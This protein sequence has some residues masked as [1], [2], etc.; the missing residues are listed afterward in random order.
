MSVAYA[1]VLSQRRREAG[2]PHGSTDEGGLLQ[3]VQHR[4]PG[5]RCARVHPDVRLCVSLIPDPSQLTEIAT[6]FSAKSS[7]GSARPLVGLRA[8]RNC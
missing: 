6:A 8:P 1:T 7:P 5:R 4:L 2:V 3:P